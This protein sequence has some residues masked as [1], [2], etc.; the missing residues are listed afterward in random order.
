MEL[1]KFLPH[2]TDNSQ[3][4]VSKTIKTS[5]SLDLKVLLLALPDA[6]RD[7][8]K[9]AIEQVDIATIENLQPL[10]AAENHALSNAIQQHIDDF[11]YEKLLTLFE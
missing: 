10:V 7:N 5:E 1:S 11:Q 3:T 6:L 2:D 4:L 9:Q 8:L